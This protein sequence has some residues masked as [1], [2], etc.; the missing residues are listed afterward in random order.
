MGDRVAVLRDG[1]LQQCAPPRELYRSPANV[2]VAGFIGSPAMNL[3]TVPVTAGAISLGDYTVELPR[4]IASAASELIIGIRPEQLHI[5]D[6]GVGVEVDLVEDLGADTYLYGSTVSPLTPQ[7]VVARVPGG[8]DV[9]RG[10]RL[11]L[12]FDLTDLH[13]FTVD[14]A[15]VVPV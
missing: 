10:A 15:R 12:R 13:F 9:R 7:S 2:F 11:S 5:A 4:E 1:V 14:G 8:T 6:H 3:Y